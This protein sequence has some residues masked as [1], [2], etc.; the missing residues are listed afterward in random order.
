MEKIYAILEYL[1]KY[2]IPYRLESNHCVGYIFYFLDG[3][4]Y[5]RRFHDSR[6]D[7]SIGQRVVSQSVENLVEQT[8][9]TDLIKDW[10]YR[11]EA[12]NLIA[13]FNEVGSYIREKH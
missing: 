7:S 6:L 5:P 4:V 12:E 3:S 13:L 11:I 10:K 1:D 2:E 8:I 9:K